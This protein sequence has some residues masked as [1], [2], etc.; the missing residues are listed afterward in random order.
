M[1]PSDNPTPPPPPP[2]NSNPPPPDAPDRATMDKVSLSPLE[3]SCPRSSAASGARLMANRLHF[4]PDPLPPPSKARF[5]LQVRRLTRPSPRAVRL[6]P[7]V[8]SKHPEYRECITST[9]GTPDAPRPEAG[10]PE[11]SPGGRLQRWRKHE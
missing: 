2:P 3:S 6:A 11:D 7:P 5:L 4:P 9:C 8:R 10:H 1:D